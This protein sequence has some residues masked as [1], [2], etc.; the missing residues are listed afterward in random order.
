MIRL[1]SELE[2][3]AKR[4]P[5]EGGG[6]DEIVAN[7]LDFIE[8]NFCERITLRDLEAAT[9]ANAFKLIRGFRRKLGMTPYAFIIQR[10]IRRGTELLEQGEPAALVA[11]EVGFVDQSHFTRHFK[12]R[13][14]LPPRRYLSAHRELAPR[15]LGEAPRVA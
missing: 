5:R 7:A 14:G 10:R 4:R 15:V 2:G 13:H 12:R 11:A 9:G 3:D 1:A 8:A 6:V